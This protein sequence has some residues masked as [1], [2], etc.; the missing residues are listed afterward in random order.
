L[1][2]CFKYIGSK[3]KQ[4][5]LSIDASEAD[6]VSA[7]SNFNYDESKVRE[8]LS[9]MILYHEYPF[10]HVEH[11]L[12]NKFMKACTPHWEKFLDLLL[13]IFALPPTNQRKRN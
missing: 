3:K 8:L 2:T 11:V 4:K 12:F 6:G 7:I 13:K 1:E 5:V 9:H 10:M